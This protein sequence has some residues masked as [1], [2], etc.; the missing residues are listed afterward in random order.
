LTHTIEIAPDPKETHYDD[1]VLVLTDRLNAKGPNL[2]VHKQNHG[3][4]GTDR[5]SYEIR[6]KNLGTERL[7]P[8]WITDTYPVSTTFNGDWNLAHG[9]HTTITHDAPNRQVIFW[10][11]RLEPGETASIDLR[12]ELDQAITGTQGLHFTNTL[13]APISGDTN[14]ADNVDQVVAYA[15]PDVYVEKWLSGGQA[16]A[17]ETVT[18]TVK[19]GNRNSWEGM[20]GMYGSRVTDTLPSS[21]AFITSTSPWSP[22]QPWAPNAVVGANLAAWEVGTMWPREAWYFEIVARIADTVQGGD[23]LTNVIEI[24]DANPADVDRNPANNRFELPITIPVVEGG[25]IYLPLVVK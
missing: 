1:N 15:G 23:V 4:W 7:E 20:D 2:Q 22:G 16:G 25:F 10:L 24:D 3:W 19:F 21:M 9:P 8:V 13:A 18:F 17:G 14:P 12:V 11:E 6:V 5:L